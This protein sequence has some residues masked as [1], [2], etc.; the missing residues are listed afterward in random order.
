MGGAAIDQSDRWGSC[1]AYR[2]RRGAEHRS[3]CSGPASSREETIVIEEGQQGE[4]APRWQAAGFP[5]VDTSPRPIVSW[6]RTLSRDA[7][8]R[9]RFLGHGGE[10][11]P[12]RRRPAEQPRLSRR[13][14]SLTKRT[15]LRCC[16]RSPTSSLAKALRE[17]KPRGGFRFPTRHRG[18]RRWRPSS[19]STRRNTLQHRRRRGLGLAAQLIRQARKSQGEPAEPYVMLCEARSLAERQT[20]GVLALVAVDEL[21][22]RFEVPEAEMS[23]SAC[24]C[25]SPCAAPM[26][27]LIA[28]VG[29]R[30]AEACCRRPVCKLGSVAWPIESAAVKRGGAA[31]TQRIDEGQKRLERST[32]CIRARKRQRKP[33][34][35]P[36][37]S[38]GQLGTRAVL[39]PGQGD[40]DQGLP[41]LAKAGERPLPPL[42][43]KLVAQRGD[44]KRRWPLADGWW[45]L[46]EKERDGM[47]DPVDDRRE[48][49]VSAGDAAFGALTWHACN[50]DWRQKPAFRSHVAGAV[51]GPA[52]W[53]GRLAG[54]GAQQNEGQHR[55]GRWV[56]RAPGQLPDGIRADSGFRV[57]SPSRTH[58]PARLVRFSCI[59]AIR[60]GPIGARMGRI[61]EEVQLP[62]LQ[63]LW[64]GL[65]G[66][67]RTYDPQTRL[68]FTFYVS[69]S[70]HSLHESDRRILG[71]EGIRPISA[72]GLSRTTKRR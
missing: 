36:G 42:A 34:N 47:G 20:D 32:G 46:A 56:R 3:G 61:A 12:D 39:L 64:P 35:R 7:G 66:G 69:D 1:D 62:A 29:F 25:D 6:P 21:G 50:S 11:P 44:V 54:D 4:V 28:G 2:F 18:P 31:L 40:W 30:E 43:A 49:L 13:R 41:R 57:Y 65:W 72:C 23:A 55:A 58:L 53:P 33:G 5:S 26:V 17:T 9:P 63:V 24:L 48:L 10:R 14:W 70:R 67:Q 71:C 27:D 22:R 15:K 51:F 37:R 16:R 38:S 60:E 45:S 8:Q 19:N 52:A 68:R 59:M